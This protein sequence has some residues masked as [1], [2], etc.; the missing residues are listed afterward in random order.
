MADCQNDYQEVE[1]QRMANEGYCN[2]IKTF[3]EG[4]LQDEACG[5]GNRALWEL[6]QNAC[7]Q[8]EE[9][10]VEIQLNSE[11]LIFKHH[12]R[13]F[14][15][16]SFY[17]LVKQDSS[18]DQNV[19]D[20]EKTVG[21]YGTGFM[22]THTFNKLVKVSG[23]YVV[24]EF[25]Q[26]PDNTQEVITKG[27]VQVKDFPLDRTKIGTVEG[28]SVMGLQLSLVD[29]FRDKDKTSFMIDDTTSFRYD[30]TPEQVGIVSSQIQGFIKLLPFV[31]ILNGKLNSVRIDDSF[32]NTHLEMNKTGYHDTAM[33]GYDGWKREIEQLCV[34]YDD[35]PGDYPLVHTIKSDK[36]DVVVIPPFPTHCGDVKDLPSLFLWY[37]LLGT[38]TFGV[39]FIFHSARFYPVETRDNIML[40]GSSSQARRTLG[41]KNGEI[42]KEMTR[43]LFNYYEFEN[44]KNTS[45]L[46][47]PFCEVSFPTGSKDEMERGFYE[48]LQTMWADVLP[49]WPVIP[50]KDGKMRMASPIVK[51]LHPDFY[52]KLSEEDLLQNESIL[53]GYAKLP[54]V[55]NAPYAFSEKDLIKWSRIVDGWRCNRDGEF[56]LSPKDVCSA[57]NQDKRGND[58][59][60]FL[61]LM[62]QAGNSD[63]IEKYPVFPNRKGDLCH[64]V[65]L[66][67]PT[68]M[69]APVY[70]LVSGLMGT[71]AAKIVDTDYVDICS[72]NDYE[73]HD[74]QKSI[75]ATIQQWRNDVL[76]SVSRTTLAE[77]TMKTLLGFSSAFSVENPSNLR[78]K[79]VPIIAEFFDME[80]VRTRTI[81]FLEQGQDEEAFFEPAFNFLVD[82]TLK[83]VSLKDVEWVKSHKPWLHSFLSVYEPDKSDDKKKKLDM[84]GVLPNQ[85]GALCKKEDLHKNKGVPPEMVVIYDDVFGKSASEDSILPGKWIDTEFEGLVTLPE[86]TPEAIAK[87]IQEALVADMKQEKTTDRKFAA[88]LRQV[89]LKLGKNDD[90]RKWFDQIDEKKAK[91][92]FEMKGGSAQESL[93]TLMDLDDK[94]LEELASISTAPNFK[95]L[96]EMARNQFD[97]EE[98]QKRQFKFTYAIG[99]MIEDAIREEVS[100]Q[101]S[102]VP[103]EIRTDDEQNGQDIIIR[104]K[105]H[106]LYYLE[107][108]AKWRFGDN[109]RAHMSSQQMK[110]AVRNEKRY[111]LLCVDCTES[112]G[113]HVPLDA[114]KEQIWESRE[115][116]RLHTHVQTEIGRILSPI[117]KA[118]VMHEDDSSLN[119]ED[120]IRVYSSLTCNISKKVFIGGTSFN[121]FMSDLKA[122]LKRQIEDLNQ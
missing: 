5:C 64:K 19:E 63:V 116:I 106:V 33:F 111:A 92:V 122:N 104:Y 97:R 40:P 48:E 29:R 31:F 59:H 55:G 58:L 14:D 117:I 32:S 90:W 102:C 69:D 11:S 65:N 15:Y 36:G 6:V 71:D 91:Y 96:L 72:F 113:A 82:Y 110:Q 13:P 12:G 45:E 114:T 103:E 115:D 77:D 49:N 108:K 80:Y 73:V 79:L 119:E 101:L 10:R 1:K 7:D 70:D 4:H 53:S 38:E 46:D 39:N 81:R 56:F 20:A 88:V 24:K 43:A 35:K 37:P 30:L 18:K 61:N 95:E 54:L 8:S 100:E 93:F 9:A 42:I 121:E 75:N 78:S 23:P 60:A 120:T 85:H 84:Y 17:S 25:H 26:K 107:C 68:F 52:A 41:V 109:D 62:K 105:G 44:S 21:R 99:K 112:T 28:P 76:P 67:N 47:M 94:N 74:L 16:K 98:E 83:L 86:D 57:I 22:T 2:K 51:L 34:K 89:I 118:Q 66:A 87:V 50:T 3:F 27:Y